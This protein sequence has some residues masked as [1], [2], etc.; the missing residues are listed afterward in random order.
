MI[1][2]DVHTINNS[3]IV[4][5]LLMFHVL[6]LFPKTPKPQNPK[7]PSFKYKIVDNHII[8]KDLINITENV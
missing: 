5:H 2:L 1:H 8:L 4:Y 6:L 7:T 3:Y